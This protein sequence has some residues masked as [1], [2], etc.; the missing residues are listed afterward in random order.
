MRG[1]HRM[2]EREREREWERERERERT[3]IM[4]KKIITNVFTAGKHW[5]LYLLLLRSLKILLFHANRLLKLCFHPTPPSLLLVPLVHVYTSDC[6][7]IETSVMC[8]S[9]NLAHEINAGPSGTILRST[10]SLDNN[11][12]A[13]RRMRIQFGR[14]KRER[15]VKLKFSD[16]KIS[17]GKR[18]EWSRP[19]E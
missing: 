15:I 17:E 9:R 18:R 8:R 10:V 4:R 14:R 12:L 6:A 16:K 1:K 3:R 7:T 11:F 13:V 19:D 2:R 5:L